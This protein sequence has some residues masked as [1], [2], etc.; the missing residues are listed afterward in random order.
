[1]ID[2]DPI[3]AEV[4]RL[5][6]RSIGELARTTIEEDAESLVSLGMDPDQAMRLAH[7]INRFILGPK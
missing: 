6:E 2:I 3:Q 1:M 5:A 7:K 4:N